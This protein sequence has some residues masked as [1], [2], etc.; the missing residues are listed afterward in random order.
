[1]RRHLQATATRE[2]SS[3]HRNGEYQQRATRKLFDR[4]IPFSYATS[5]ATASRQLDGAD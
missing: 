4:P 1:M 3:V 2:R 5:P